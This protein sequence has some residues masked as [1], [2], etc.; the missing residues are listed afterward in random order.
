MEAR[1]SLVSRALREDEIA[2]E[3][4]RVEAVASVNSICTDFTWVPLSY[5]SK[6]LIAGFPLAASSTVTT[7]IVLVR[8]LISRVPSFIADNE[9]EIVRPREKSVGSTAAVESMLYNL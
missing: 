9:D 7:I 3:A 5:I 1:I 2:N 6:T 4:Y 8:A